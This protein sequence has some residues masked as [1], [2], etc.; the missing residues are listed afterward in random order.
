[1]L[2]FVF[3][4][5]A[6]CRE[7]LPVLERVAARHRDVTF[8]IVAVRADAAAARGLRSN[9]PVGYDHDGAVANEY[10]VVV[11][12]TITYVGRGGKI[13]GSTVGRAERGGRGSVGAE[14]RVSV[15][16]PILAGAVDPR[17]AAEL[18]G[19]GLACCAFD[20][21]G[22]V[23]APLPARRCARGCARSR[24]ARAARR[25]S[26][27]ARGRSRTPT[28]SCTARL[29]SSPTMQRVPA[30]EYML[31]RLKRGAYPSRGRAGRRAAGR[32]GGDGGGRLGARRRAGA[33]RLALAGERVVVADEGG[34]IVPCVL[35]RRRRCA[36]RRSGWS[37]YAICAA[38]VPEIAVEEALWTAWDVVAAGLSHPRV[39][40]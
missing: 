17:I 38:G 34:T 33:L 22:D 37:L 19:L 15:E 10:A 21:A 23:D 35:A 3:H 29:G 7:Q 30:E 27:C 2:A 4:P 9:L 28:G 32:D 20:V 39:R 36:G 26:R 16:P 40:A 18:P 31:E 13:E 12:P 6:R 1:M 5:V 11:C 8:R 14:D 24:T 25:R